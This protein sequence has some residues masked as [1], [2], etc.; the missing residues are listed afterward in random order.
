MLAVDATN[1]AQKAATGIHGHNATEITLTLLESLLLVRRKT[2]HCVGK[3]LRT[4]ILV[5]SKNI[6]FI[7]LIRYI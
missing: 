3:V 2:V 4:T 5:A 1:T 6:A 7:I